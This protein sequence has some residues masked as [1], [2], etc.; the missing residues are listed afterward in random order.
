MPLSGAGLR[1]LV[2]SQ[3]AT[4]R[5]SSRRAHRHPRIWSAGTASD[6]PKAANYFLTFLADPPPIR[7]YCE[8]SATEFEN[9]QLTVADVT[10]PSAP[11]T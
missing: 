5:A 6:I 1:V 4:R 10:A 9:L 8:K 3:S 2:T 11:L 7:H